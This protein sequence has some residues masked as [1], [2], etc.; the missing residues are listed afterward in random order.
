MTH[1]TDSPRTA[2]DSARWFV[3]VAAGPLVL[4]GFFLPWAAGPGILA[5][6]DFTGFK[7]VQFAGRLQLLE[8]PVFLG[9]SLVLVRALV[10]LVAVAATWLTLLAP[11]HRAHRL[12][13]VSGWYLAGFAAVA[14]LIGLAKSGI[15]VPPAG[16][17]LWLLGAAAFVASEWP[18]RKR[19]PRS[20]QSP[21]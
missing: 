1:P 13:L 6:T 5:G 15:V 9:S 2:L 14:L 4:V 12:Y 3:R 10:L 11:L 21:Q 20:P 17:A 16:L 7:L 8:L 19:G 18:I